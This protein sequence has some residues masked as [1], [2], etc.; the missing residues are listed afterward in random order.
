MDGITSSL[1]CAQTAVVYNLGQPPAQFRILIPKIPVY[2]TGT[3]DLMTALLLG[4]SNKYP[5]NLNKAAEL[6]VSSLQA[7]LA[8]TLNDYKRAGH[9]CETSSLEIRLIQSQDDIRN[10]KINYTAETYN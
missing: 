1:T 2:F 3:G 7:L 4:W 10:P 8:R 9:D 5:D 6:S